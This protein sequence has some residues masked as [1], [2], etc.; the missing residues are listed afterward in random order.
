MPGTYRSDHVGSLFRADDVK[1][2]RNGLA[3]VVVLFV[4]ACGSESH[5]GWQYL[6]P[7]S[8]PATRYQSIRLSP[9]G[10]WDPNPLN[11]P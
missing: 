10:D 5:D 2:A 7:D 4:V 1:Q 6:G 11:H 8:F 3:L 9:L